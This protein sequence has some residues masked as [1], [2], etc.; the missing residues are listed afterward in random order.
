[1][2][3]NNIIE[4]GYL[5]LNESDFNFDSELLK[6]VHKIFNQVRSN[7]EK[8]FTSYRNHE[9]L[10]N[11][12]EIKSLEDFNKKIELD[13]IEAKNNPNFKWFQLWRNS[14]ITNFAD[15]SVV[16]EYIQTIVKSIYDYNPPSR[17]IV[18]EFTCFTKGCGI[19]PHRDGTDSNYSRPSYRICGI[20]SYFSEDWDESHGG[21]LI[22][23]GKDVIIPSK[24]NIVILD[25]TQNNL[26]HEV[27]KVLKDNK[28][29]LSLTTYVSND[30]ILI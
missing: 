15:N 25:Y 11:D 7:P 10:N 17:D 16:Y 22:I 5:F 19:A 23:N 2:I 26:E 14:S 27:T 18:T 8:W 4:D 9:S 24:G 6:K 1:M 3:T 13:E 29:R 12:N 30:K 21:N 28:Y 20:L